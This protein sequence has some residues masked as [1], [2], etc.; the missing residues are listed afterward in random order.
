MTFVSLQ[1][2]NFPDRVIRHQVFLGELHRK[3]DLISE[4][5]KE[6]ATFDMQELGR[7]HGRFHA[8]NFPSHVLRHQDL[9]IKLSE[10]RF[11]ISAPGTSPPETAEHRLTREDS[12]F[13]RVDRRTGAV[14]F[15]ATSFPPGVE[16]DLIFD[17]TPVLAH[18]IRHRDFHL[19]LDQRI[20]DP[21]EPFS[22]TEEQV[23]SKLASDRKIYS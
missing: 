8:V 15:Y 19:F 6:D 20:F 9:R 14:M 22:S 4:R 7:N 3:V 12:I 5:D 17:G 13:A 1:S 16:N 18:C 23:G 11:D 21:G 2:V 10:L